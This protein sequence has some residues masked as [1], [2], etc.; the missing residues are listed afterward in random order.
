VSRSEETRAGPDRG[1]SALKEGGRESTGGGLEEV[2]DK[3]SRVL[4]R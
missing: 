2:W 3:E 4:V 1:E